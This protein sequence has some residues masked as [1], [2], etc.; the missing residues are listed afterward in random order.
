MAALLNLYMFAQFSSLFWPS[1]SDG[2]KNV[3]E[4]NGRRG[5]AGCDDRIAKYVD[6][7]LQRTGMEVAST[8]QGGRHAAL[9]K[10]AFGLGRLVGA[11]ILERQVAEQTLRQA[12]K[13]CGLDRDSGGRAAVDGTIGD[14]LN[15]GI[16][17]PIDT[18]KIGRGRKRAEAPAQK[19]TAESEAAAEAAAELEVVRKEADAEASRNRQSALAIWK[20]CRPIGSTL[21]EVYLRT[22][23]IDL[24]WPAA[25]GFSPRVRNTEADRDLPAL[26]GAVSETPDSDVLGVHRIWLTS[27]GTWKAAVDKPKKALGNF[28]GAAIWFGIPGKRLVIA[29]GIENA[30]SAMMAGEKFVCAAV[31][32][33]NIANITPPAGVTEIM[34][35]GDRDP[36]GEGIDQ[37]GRDAIAKGAR[38]WRETGIAV[39]VAL[40]PPLTKMPTTC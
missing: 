8:K 23:G 14:G 20:R 5:S 16:L 38:R 34:V 31:G 33:S 26:I 12:A 4:G 21:G 11:R 32:G 29:E 36:D 19:P 18:T 39:R 24:P 9:N 25:L 7:A 2:S 1:T 30:L 13:M 27:D 28:K 17:K 35:F 3:N 40:A 10:A 22:R 15:A 37:T 6:A